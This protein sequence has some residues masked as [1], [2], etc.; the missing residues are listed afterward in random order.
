MHLFL[1][2]PR[3][4]GKSTFLRWALL[5]RQAYLAGFVVQRVMEGNEPVGFRVAQA[6]GSYPSLVTEYAADMDG[7]FIFRGRMDRSVLDEA[8]DAARTASQK[9]G[10]KLILLDEIGGIELESPRFMNALE[11]ILSGNKPCV[12]VLKSEENLRR[13]LSRL[14]LGN[15]CLDLRARLEEQI[16]RNGELLEYSRA[17][18]ANIGK[19]LQACLGL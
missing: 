10:C 9:D 11:R 4:A 1:Y 17:E 19:R 14:R 8:I 13:S 16:A 6:N 7:V 18:E 12:G 5:P 2:G 15:R 3:E